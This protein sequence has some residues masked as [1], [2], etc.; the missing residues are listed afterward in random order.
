MNT[1]Q[2][3]IFIKTAELCS[4][5]KTAEYYGTTYQGI[6]YQIDNLEKEFNTRFF[7]RNKKGSSLT[8][9]G[10]A[11]Y[12]Y[13][14]SVLEKAKKLK[15]DFSTA[16]VTRIGVDINYIVPE[17]SKFLYDNGQLLHLFI[18]PFYYY[19]LMEQLQ[20]DNI[21]CFFGHEKRHYKSISFEKIYEDSVSVAFS[22]NNPLSNK[23]TIEYKD[24][25]NMRIHL[26]RFDFVNKEIILQ[27]L[28][29]QAEG[30]ELLFN[31]PASIALA[32]LHNTDAI[33]IM[34]TIDV[35]I[36]GD[37]LVSLP[38]DNTPL[39]YGIYYKNRTEQIAQIIKSIKTTMK[40]AEKKTND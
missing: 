13:A 4:L 33:F 26:G 1:N 9:N 28:R 31:T 10:Q 18:Q 39:F 11:F 2:L 32:E 24:L 19:S 15:H 35:S 25:A 17:L 29:D 7:V 3:E 40:I 27:S 8:K 38:L 14:V 5:T 34:P 30:C 20:N 21:D 37:R 6:S 22:P 36:F 16:T 23:T 12:E